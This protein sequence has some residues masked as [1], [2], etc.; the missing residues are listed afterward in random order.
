LD[1]VLDFFIKFL[2]VMAFIG[3]TTLAASWSLLRGFKP[4]IVVL[5]GSVTLAVFLGALFLFMQSSLKQE[6]FPAFQQYFDEAWKNQSQWL[7]SSGVAAEKI[8]MFKEIYE[9]YIF[10]AFPS[11]IAVN[12]LVMGLMAYYLASA[13]LSRV[14]TRV[15][16]AIAFREWVIPEPLVFGLI[17]G[18]V[19]K[20]F[21]RENAWMDILANNFLVFF[22]GLYT[23]GGLSII[24]FFFNKWRL[25]AAMR[26]FSYIVLL[27][28]VFETVCCF[29]VLD[30]W[31]DFRKLKG[32]APTP[33][34]TPT[35]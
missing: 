9:K 10:Q 3:M 13:I 23:L 24:S 21:F 18:G 20:L 15:S 28:L 26:L 33:E 19:I 11:W 6:T 1:V 31:F 34:P 22:V 35:A 5:M 8:A 25:P 27:N 16:K 4:R 29:G 12:C 2:V 32:S 30:V 7:T 14:T 17:I